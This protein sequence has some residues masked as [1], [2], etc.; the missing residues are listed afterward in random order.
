VLLVASLSLSQV[1]YVVRKSPGQTA[2]NLVAQIAA[3]LSLVLTGFGVLLRLLDWAHASQ[4]CCACVDDATACLRSC[5]R[6]LL[7]YCCCCACCMKSKVNKT[8]SSAS[9]AS[10]HA[11]PRREQDGDD[12]D[13]DGNDDGGVMMSVMPAA[14]A[15]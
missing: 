6:P 5:C 11:P 15:P 4:S 2:L 1:T 8:A 14:G 7:G 9:A 10:P 12:A 13:D 3:L